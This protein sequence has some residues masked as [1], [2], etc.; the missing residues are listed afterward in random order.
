[1][2]REAGK[3]RWEHVHPG[4]R[5]LSYVFCTIHPLLVPESHLLFAV[6][7]MLWLRFAQK[8]YDVCIQQIFFAQETWS[9]FFTLMLPLPMLPQGLASFPPTF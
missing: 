2:N 1:M 5:L 7:P 4:T 6:G 9:R 8:P 3:A